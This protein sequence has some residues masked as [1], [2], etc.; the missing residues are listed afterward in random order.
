MDWPET[1]RLMEISVI[2][3]IC[4]YCLLTWYGRIPKPCKINYKIRILHGINDRKRDWTN[5]TS[6]LVA[7]RHRLS[8]L[9]QNW[10]RHTRQTNQTITTWKVHFNRLLMLLIFHVLFG[11]TSAKIIYI[12]VVFSFVKRQVNLFGMFC[13]GKWPWAITYL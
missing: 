7:N 12:D 1:G 8:L 11:F 2:F 4:T 5:S 9:K 3:N 13:F 10:I 6:I